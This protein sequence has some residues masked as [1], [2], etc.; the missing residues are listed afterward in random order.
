M[1][2]A[3]AEADRALAQSPG[4]RATYPGAGTG[5]RRRLGA[6]SSGRWPSGRSRRSPASLGSRPSWR[7]GAAAARLAGD[8][9]AALAGDAGTR[10][11]ARPFRQVRLVEPPHHGENYLLKEMGFRVARKHAAKLRRIAVLRGAGCRC[12]GCLLALALPAPARGQPAGAAGRRR[13]PWPAR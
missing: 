12:A 5:D 4:C 2:Y 10:H 1:I 13:R 7:L 6:G 11:R 8:R 3:L 9:R